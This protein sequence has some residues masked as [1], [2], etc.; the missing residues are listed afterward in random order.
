MSA[1]ARLN[2]KILIVKIRM[3]KATMTAMAPGWFCKF[4]ASTVLTN[5]LVNIAG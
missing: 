2:Q 3:P 1:D 4:G 5:V